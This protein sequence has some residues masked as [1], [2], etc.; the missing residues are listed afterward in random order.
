MPNKFIETI[1]SVDS[2]LFIT[3]NQYTPLYCP[4]DNNLNDGSVRTCNGGFEYYNAN[5]SCWFP[6]SGANVN[7]ELGPHVETVMRWAFKKMAEEEKLSEL[8][9]KY[10][11]LKQAK[12]NYEIVKALVQ[13]E[14]V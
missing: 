12:D 10:P 9:K 7:I 13:H 8:A 11:A 2:N 5:S 6:L 1:T 14:V 3:S 4:D